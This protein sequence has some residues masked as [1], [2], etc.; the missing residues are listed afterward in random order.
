MLYLNVFIKISVFKNRKK[1]AETQLWITLWIYVSD[2]ESLSS[3]WLQLLQT[4]TQSDENVCKRQCKLSFWF[5]LS[6]VSQMWQ[7][8]WTDDFDKPKK[9]GAVDHCRWSKLKILYNIT[10]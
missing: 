7:M 4:D 9:E 1:T 5:R 10:T 6:D 8:W 2:D 3:E